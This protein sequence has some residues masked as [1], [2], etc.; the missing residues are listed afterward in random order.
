MSD[1]PGFQAR[2]SEVLERIDVGELSQRKAA[3]ELGIGFATLKRLLD[4]RGVAET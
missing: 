1:E 2:F 3:L 4:A